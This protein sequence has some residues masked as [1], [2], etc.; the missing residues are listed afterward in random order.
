MSRFPVLPKQHPQCL[1]SSCK[2]AL[3]ADLRLCTAANMQTPARNAVS[4]MA[5]RPCQYVNAGN[6]KRGTTAR[7]QS[8]QNAS[9]IA[10][11]AMVAFGMRLRKC[12]QRRLLLLGSSLVL[13]VFGDIAP[14]IFYDIINSHPLV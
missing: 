12:L 3:W 14:S 7:F 4:S 11:S 10:I 8:N 9:P 5:P 2:A 13:V 1:Q 6:V